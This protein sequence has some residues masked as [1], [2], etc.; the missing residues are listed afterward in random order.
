MNKFKVGDKYRVVIDDA[1]CTGYKIEDIIVVYSVYRYND[2]DCFDD[3]NGMMFTENDVDVCIELVEDKSYE[4]RLLE[5]AEEFNVYNK[6]TE[7]EIHDL[8]ES[9]DSVEKHMYYGILDL[10]CAERKKN[11]ESS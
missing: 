3:T 6:N 9:T 1:A 10:I 4:E 8:M 5:L 2:A 7:K 11:A